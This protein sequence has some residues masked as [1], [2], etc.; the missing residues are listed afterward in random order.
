MLILLYCHFDENHRYDA[1]KNFSPCQKR[2]HKA[3]WAVVT[4]MILP[5]D[6]Q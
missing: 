6:L 1:D 5:L 2:G 4:G 3:H